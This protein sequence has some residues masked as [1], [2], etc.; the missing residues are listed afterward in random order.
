MMPCHT[1]SKPSHIPTFS[2]LLMFFIWS[3]FRFIYKIKDGKQKK[4]F[5]IDEHSGSITTASSL[6]QETTESYQLSVVA[7]DM[8]QTCHKG[9]IKVKVIVLDKNVSEP[10]FGK[11]EYSVNVPENASRNTHLI[12]VCFFSNLIRTQPQVLLSVEYDD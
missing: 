11:P 2:L 10:K 7:M 12:E 4:H 5:Q 8:N 6:D 9:L 1:E 3:K